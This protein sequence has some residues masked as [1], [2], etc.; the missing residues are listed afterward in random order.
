MAAKISRIDAIRFLTNVPNDKA[1]WL[2]GG[3]IL[4]NLRELQLEL[5][6]MPDDIFTFHVNSE[7]N[8]F[9]N[10]VKD[11]IGDEKLAIDLKK[12]KNKIASANAVKRRILF[13]DAL[14]TNL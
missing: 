8:D 6:T 4:N 11:V 10:W 7:K 13:L 5:I 12:A 1:F 9:S 3:R 2:K 14:V